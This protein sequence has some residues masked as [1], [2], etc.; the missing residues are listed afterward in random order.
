MGVLKNGVEKQGNCK[1]F[2]TCKREHNLHYEISPHFQF[3]FLVLEIVNEERGLRESLE[4]KTV[5]ELI[6]MFPELDNEKDKRL[7]YAWEKYTTERHER[8]Q[9]NAHLRSELLKAN[10]KIRK[11]KGEC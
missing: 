6:R 11:L 9:L 5:L 8:K 1:R 10:A 7:L 4:E 2:K 3:R